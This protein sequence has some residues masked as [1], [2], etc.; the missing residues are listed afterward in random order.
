MHILLTVIVICYEKKS[1]ADRASLLQY[2]YCGFDLLLVPITLSP[3]ILP[4]PLLLSFSFTSLTS[5]TKTV[6]NLIKISL[7]LTSHQSLCLLL[8][9][10]VL[11]QRNLYITDFWNCQPCVKHAFL[12]I[13][14]QNEL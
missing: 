14:T 4:I 12:P 5:S 9:K 10:R 3:L 1:G 2:S 11:Q 6:I 8:F 13:S 7:H